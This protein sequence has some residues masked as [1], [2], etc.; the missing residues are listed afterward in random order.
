M[1]SID[2]LRLQRQRG[3]ARLFDTRANLIVGQRVPTAESIRRLPR[4]ST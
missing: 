2:W 3:L 4:F 1:W